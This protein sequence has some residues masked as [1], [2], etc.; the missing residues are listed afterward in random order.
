MVWIETRVWSCPDTG[1]VPPS[2]RAGHTVCA[3]VLSPSVSVPRFFLS[4]L[5][6]LSTSLPLTLCQAVSHQGNLCV[7]GG[8]D[9]QRVFNDTAVLDI[10]A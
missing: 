1:G 4:C 9:L 7:F 2:P 8:G 5:H 6:S 10:G 3:F